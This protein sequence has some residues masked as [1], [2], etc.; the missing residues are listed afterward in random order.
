VQLDLPKG[1]LKRADF[2]FA[3]GSAARGRQP[4]RP[5]YGGFFEE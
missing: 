4:P 1:E 2:F 5:K 3:L